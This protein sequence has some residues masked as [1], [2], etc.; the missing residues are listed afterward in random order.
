MQVFDAQARDLA[1]QVL[2]R[3]RA[4]RLRIATAESCTGGLISA[5]LTAI[6]G[7]S[8]VLDCGFVTY[9]NTAKVDML[10]V[11]A[12]LIASQGAVSEAVAGAM[13]RGACR[14]S[15]AGLSVAVT[16]IAGPG[17]GSASKPV[18]FVCFGLTLGEDTQTQSKVFSGN[19]DQVRAQTVLHALTLLRDALP[20]TVA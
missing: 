2:T 16:G 3:A 10:G 9:S 7:S 12:G 17:G 20:G 11:D 5:C 14:Q 19:R 15:S 1:E 13:A 4:A 18:G 6:A 8:E